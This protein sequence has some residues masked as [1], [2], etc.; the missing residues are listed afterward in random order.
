MELLKQLKEI[1]WKIKKEKYHNA[2]KII[3]LAKNF[4]NRMLGGW[5]VS[6]N[7]NVSLDIIEDNLNLPWSCYGIAYNLNLSKAPLR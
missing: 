3:N 1:K 2:K 7:E 5:D 6:A 4:K